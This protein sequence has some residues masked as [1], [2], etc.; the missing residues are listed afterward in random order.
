MRRPCGECCFY[1]IW[2][3]PSPWGGVLAASW[4]LGDVWGSPSWAFGCVCCCFAPGGF[5]GGSARFLGS[6]GSF[7][8]VRGCA[9]SLAL[10]AF[11]A[12]LGGPWRRWV[13]LCWGVCVA[14]VSGVART[15]LGALLLCWWVGGLPVWAG[16]GSCLGSARGSESCCYLGLLSKSICSCCE[17]MHVVFH[18]ISAVTSLE[19]R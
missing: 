17:F 10:G 1:Y 4:V 7:R 12:L 18:F 5:V 13:V 3:I 9:R 2:F 8:L 16:L 11:L 19:I 14:S 6:V 15:P